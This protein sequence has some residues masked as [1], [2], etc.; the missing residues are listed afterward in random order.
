MTKYLNKIVIA[1][2]AMALT[3]CG[4]DPAEV[5]DNAKPVISSNGITPNPVD[6]QGY[7]VGEVIPVNYVFTDDI[8]LGNYNIEIHNNFDHHTHSTSEVSC[9]FEANKKPV[10]PFVYNKDFSIPAGS[11]TFT[12]RQ[13]I[14]I[15]TDV[16]P[17]DYH[18][19]IRLTDAAGHQEIK[20][21][22]VKITK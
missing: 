6:C 20:G 15:P 14:Q 4:D 18:F 5:I 11:K 3:A 13:D 7:K 12:A 10:R 19:M 16:D 1:I 8:E 2:A 9:Q 17:G 22:S 21:I